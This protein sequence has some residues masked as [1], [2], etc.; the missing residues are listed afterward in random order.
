MTMGC[1]GG[2]LGEHGLAGVEPAA[3]AAWAAGPRDRVGGEDG[4]R[5]QCRTRGGYGLFVGWCSRR[6]SVAVGCPARGRAQL[7]APRHGQPGAATPAPQGTMRIAGGVAAEAPPWDRRAA[8]GRSAVHRPGRSHVIIAINRCSRAQLGDPETAA[9][10]RALIAGAIGLPLR[11]AELRSALRVV[12]H[13][14]CSAG[15]PGSRSVCDWVAA[16]SAQTVA[17]RPWLHCRKAHAV[18]ASRSC[19]GSAADRGA[20]PALGVCA[21]RLR[22]PAQTPAAG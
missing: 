9:S 3:K 17:S 12:G 20:T 15:V 16:R 21:G 6:P 19:I 22:R 18:G 7:G 14:R 13:R 11:I 5:S 1:V 4:D 8:L 2:G 10:R